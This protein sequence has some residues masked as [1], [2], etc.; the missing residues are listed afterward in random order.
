M[1]LVGDHKQLPPVFDMNII[2]KA[3]NSLLKVEELKKGL[4]MK[5]FDILPEEN[6]QKLT[7]QYRMNPVIGKM[8]SKIFYDCEID[9]GV[10]ISERNHGISD[11]G[12]NAI[13]WLST[14][15]RADDK[16]EETRTTNQSFI[17]YLEA[18]IVKEQLL[19]IDKNITDKDYKIGIITGYSAQKHYL[20][21]EIKNLNL[22]N[23]ADNIDINTV[24]AFQGRQTDII[25]YSTVRSSKKNSSIGFQKERTI[26]CSI[27]KSKKVIDN[28]R[29]FGFY[30]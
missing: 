14:S 20:H 12:N 18:K 2:R 24:D 17:N 26:K 13:I 7:V 9:D 22:K 10:S 16:K 6:K 1:I 29:G 19:K 23:I 15:K 4:F 25:I 3:N 27:F 21:K 28:R 11:Y 30:K 5:F 8:I